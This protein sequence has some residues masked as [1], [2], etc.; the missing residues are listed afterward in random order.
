MTTTTTRPNL[1]TLT[2]WEVIRYCSRG[3]ES[4]MTHACVLERATSGEGMC[5]HLACARALCSAA[6]IL[7]KAS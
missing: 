1:T 5:L 6:S 3:P 7:G 4:L 2:T